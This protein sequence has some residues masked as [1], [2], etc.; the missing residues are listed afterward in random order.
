LQERRK[1]CRLLGEIYLHGFMD[2]EAMNL[3]FEEQ[4]VVVV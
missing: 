4:E 1:G 3:K 2:G